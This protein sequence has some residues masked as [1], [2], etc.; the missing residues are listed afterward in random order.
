MATQPTDKRT[1]IA[2]PIAINGIFFFCTCFVL[3]ATV[4]VGVVAGVSV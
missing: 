1:Q 2:D 4:V 3:V